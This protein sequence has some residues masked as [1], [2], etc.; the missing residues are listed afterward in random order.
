MRV[1]IAADAMAGLGPRGASEVIAEAFA[2]AGAQVAV[3]PLADGGP[4]FADAFAEVDPDGVIA[5][6]GTLAEVLEA[7]TRGT[8]TLRMDL[9]NLAPHTWSELTAVGPAVLAGLADAMGERKVVAVVR[10]GEELA[11]LTG[12]TGRVAER[13]REHGADLA[14]TL[15][16]DDAVSSWLSSLGADGA[17]PGAGAADG[18]GAVIL[19]LG[20]QVSSG[21]D[22]LIEGFGMTTT[23]SRADLL[24]TGAT[25]LDF[26]AVGGDVVKEV[27][28]MGTEALRPVIAIVG[29]NFVSSRELRLA[30]IESAHAILDGV[31]EDEPVPAQLAEVA[32]KVAQSWTW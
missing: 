9:T 16:A 25:L 13:G 15:A 12:L 20:G 28:R 14:E 7:L 8:S 29:R 21:I 2:E 32:R 31:G 6:P 22:A 3:V 26:H 17:A 10:S 18:L 23:V 11:T 27:A 24:V 4:A 5:Q 30:G 19:A 1:L